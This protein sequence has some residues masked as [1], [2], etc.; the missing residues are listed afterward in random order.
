ML[1]YAYLGTTAYVWFD[2]IHH[3]LYLRRRLKKEGYQ[4]TPK[5]YFG[6]AD[7]VLGGFY[8][9]ALSVPIIN[10]C[11]PLS[12][13]NKNRAYDEYKN[14]LLDAG[15]ID[16]VEFDDNIMNNLKQ[17]SINDKQKII[18][19]V[20]KVD[21]AKLVE[22]VNREGRI[23]YSSMNSDEEELNQGGYTYKKSLFNNK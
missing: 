17:G 1:F 8:L 20:I 3:Q 14:Y 19:N 21:D 6:L 16:K 13:L 12:H 7:V 2:A 9:I 15:A 11:Y 5:K 4:Y 23:Y 22:R 10:L 18:Q